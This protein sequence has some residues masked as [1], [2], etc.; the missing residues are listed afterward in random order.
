MYKTVIIEDD[1]VITLLNRRYVELDPRFSVVHTFSGAR[2]ALLWLRTNPVDL[3]ILDVYMPQMSGIELLK[4]LRLMGVDSDVMMVTSANDAATIESSMRLGITDY[5]I[6]P[7]G[8]ERFRKALDTFCNRRNAIHDGTFTQDS[9]DSALNHISSTVAAIQSPQTETPPKGLQKKTLETIENYLKENPSGHT[10]D[11]IA[12]H[13]GLSVVTV[14]HYVNYL[15]EKSI[16]ISSMDYN[17]GGRPC[18]IYRYL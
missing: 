6:K 8:Y 4:Q 14:R 7:F 15:V 18:I 16:I 13:V 12:S 9:L 2:P 17:T 1:P 10:C 11:E 5:L 3:I